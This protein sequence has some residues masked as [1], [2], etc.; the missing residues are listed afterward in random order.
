MG[1]GDQGFYDSSEG[2]TVS[3]ANTCEEGLS[4]VREN[5]SETCERKTIPLNSPDW[6]K[7]NE[8][9]VSIMNCREIQAPNR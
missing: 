4:W 7:F 3:Q 9:P 2:S 6:Q 1:E 5:R 8:T